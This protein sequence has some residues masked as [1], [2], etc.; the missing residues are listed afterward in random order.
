MISMSDTSMP[1]VLVRIFGA[2]CH[3]ELAVIEA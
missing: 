2:L 1:D 3:E